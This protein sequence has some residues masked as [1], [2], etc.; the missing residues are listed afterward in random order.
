MKNPAEVAQRVFDALEAKLSKR[1]PRTRYVAA[2]EIAYDCDSFVVTSSEVYQGFPGSRSPDTG[3]GQI[4][5]SMDFRVYIIRTV[6]ALDG[7]AAVNYRQLEK[8]S[9]LAL[10]D[11]SALAQALID[12]DA[13]NTITD[14]CDDVT[15]GGVVIDG[16]EGDAIATILTISI[17][18]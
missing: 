5:L 18:L 6:G 12:A 10:E 11:A 8:V 17:Q 2:G 1:L 13:D 7:H 3:H 15:F 14:P 16:P 4:V 9:K